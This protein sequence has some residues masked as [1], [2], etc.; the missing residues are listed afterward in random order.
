[1]TQ[2]SG[3]TLVPAGYDPRVRPWYMAAAASK[4]AI[5]TPPYIDA[6]TKLPIITFA[7][8]LYSNDGKAL[9]VAGGDVQLKRIVEEV[10][11]ARL[12]G[13]GYAFL[14][15]RDG[16]VIAHPAKD[17]GL[18]KIE[19]VIPGL[20]LSEL[21]TDGRLR[22]FSFDGEP[23]LTTLFPIGKTDWLLGVVVPEQKAMAPIN[24]LLYGMLAVLALSLLV[25]FFV[26]S[27]GISRLMSGIS[28][29]RDA[30]TE[31]SRGGGDL[32]ASLPLDSS[33]EIAET[34]K[35]FN[36]F[37]ASL[38]TM[39]KDIK[40]DSMRLL[41]G[42]ETVTQATERI[43]Q[44]SAAQTSAADGT[45]SA[46]EAMTASI[47]N[48][49]ESAR[50]AENMTKESECASRKLAVE[51]REAAEEI[52][53]IETTVRKLE[54]VLKA[55]DGR[56]MEISKIVGVIKDIADQTN[57]LA[58]NAAIEAAR[59]G[60]QGR[61]FAV[62]ADEVRKLAERTG[63]STVEISK[64][65]QLIQEE[66]KIAVGSM[67]MAVD[68]VNSGVEKSQAV[69]Q[70]IDRIER[71]ATAVAQALVL[72]ARSTAQQS[73]S[74]QEIASNIERIHEMAHEADISVQET[75][76]QTQQLRQLAQDMKVQMDRFR[77]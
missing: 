52:A 14:I 61:G 15:T 30:M 70:S 28:L 13:D 38:R 23:V 22:S 33:D 1:M 60:E 20:K 49:A 8:A 50:N 27:L 4:E 44:S 21:S 71:N 19:T 32:T 68:Q 54:T 51:V 55:L 18:K 42:I 25:A 45:S 58:L 67:Q 26:T 43:S 63:V 48:I 64:M 57:L 73:E 17:S 16:L 62:V 59:A 72:I 56:S 10:L 39:V 6:S 65:I 77:A 75:Q 69:T 35:A 40:A 5:A 9:A 2:F 31:I 66:T 36:R 74:S 53:L 7:K 12:P 46:V 37:L 11:A 3:A 34:K 24:R 76:S 29:L 41:D 47:G